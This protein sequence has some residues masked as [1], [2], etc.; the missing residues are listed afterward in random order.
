MKK[1]LILIVG[2]LLSTIT[3]SQ[4][5]YDVIYL[6]NGSVIKGTIVS[7]EPETIIRTNDG[8]LFSYKSHEIEQITKTLDF[9][10]DVYGGDFSY[11]ITL[12]GGGLIGSPIRYHSSD[13]IAF[14]L[15]IYYL[16]M[17]IE[18][19]DGDYS[20]L[21]YYHTAVFEWGSN[22]YL[23][24][25]FK[26]KSNKVKLNGLTSKAGIGIGGY[27]SFYF[28]FGWIHE[29]FRKANPKKSF[30]F[31]LGPGINFQ[32]VYANSQYYHSVSPSIYAKFLWC[33]YSN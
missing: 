29:S 5:Y 1:T 25:H 23:K 8:H 17:P 6:K 30:T 20:S 2:L 7:Y 15:G 31:E 14:E 3:Y 13:K 27:N 28:A 4:T 18:I 26:E 12:G 16:P 22:L 19:N 24:K 10:L 33:L 21:N 32:E 9:D 11:G